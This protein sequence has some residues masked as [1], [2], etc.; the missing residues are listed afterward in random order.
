MSKFNKLY[1]AIQIILIWAI[2]F[3]IPNS[4]LLQIVLWVNLLYTTWTLT[5][6][7]I[8]NDDFIE[9]EF[10]VKSLR[11]A[12]TDEMMRVD[13]IV[14]IFEEIEKIIAKKEAKK[15]TAKKTTAKK[16]TK[17]VEKKATKTTKKTATKKPAVKK[18][19]ITVV[20]DK[21]ITKKPA[22]KKAVKKAVKKK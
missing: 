17:S 13:S 22:T 21:E 2:V 4:L 10:T 16:A 5:Y 8:I 18:E 3:T 14:D 11:Q 15:T 6:T 9:L 1:I 12:I 19:I 7:E 20:V